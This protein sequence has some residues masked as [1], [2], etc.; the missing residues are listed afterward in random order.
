MEEL[1]RELEQI[2]VK[3]PSVEIVRYSSALHKVL[4]FSA[5]YMR[6]Y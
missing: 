6:F 1:K 2:N 3:V 5:P 4:E